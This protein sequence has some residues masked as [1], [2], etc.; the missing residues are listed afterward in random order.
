M[1]KLLITVILCIPLLLS[2]YLIAKIEKDKVYKIFYYLM[3]LGFS[4]YSGVGII[5]EYESIEENALLYLVQ[6]LLFIFSF[7]A[8]SRI[9]MK[10]NTSSI[11]VNIDQIS[12]ERI[13]YVIGIIYILTYVYRCLFSGISINEL[14]DIKKLFSTYSTTTFATRVTRRSSLAY[15]IITNQ[16]ASICAPFYYI[17]LY[18]LKKKHLTFIVIYMVPVILLT[19]ADGYLSRNRIAVYLAFLF[20][21]LVDE[22]LISKRIARSLVIIGLPIML[23]C[24]SALASIRSRGDIN[25]DIVESIKGVIVSEINYPQYY[26]YCVNKGKEI[27]SLNFII[28]IFIVC[29]PSQLYTLV[30]FEAPNLS[31]SLTEAVTGLSYAETNNY[32]I[33]LPSVLG[34]ALMLYGK[35]FAFVHGIIYGVIATMFLKILKEHKCL[36]YLL[37]YYLL[38][39]FRQF[40]GGSQY[41]ISMWEVQLVPLIII[42]AVLS[43]ILKGKQKDGKSIYNYSNI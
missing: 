4:L 9:T 1:V 6:F 30:G 18:N 22:E 35:Y 11:M 13:I 24:F 37:I 7:L 31:Y 32:Y 16:V 41:V 42:V 12:S 21:Y 20:I 40:R 25:S 15:N 17:M 3:L 39:F 28:Y 5:T 8:A 43:A 10:I 23:F 26:D 19:M 38:D 29:I 14:F 34:E 27:N 2:C 33:L 36:R